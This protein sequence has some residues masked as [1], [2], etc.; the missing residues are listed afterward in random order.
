MEDNPKVHDR[1]A[2]ELPLNA[3]VAPLEVADPYNPEDRIVVL[4]SIST[5]PLAWM[6]SHNRIDDASYAAGREWQAIF[7]R[8]TLGNIR[9]ID[10]TKEAVSGGR[11]P[12]SLTDSRIKAM[13]RL[14]K[15]DEEL[16]PE[17]SRLVFDI[18]GRGLFPNQAAQ[19][20]GKYGEYA[21]RSMS[22]KFKRALLIVAVELGFAN[23]QKSRKSLANP[24]IRT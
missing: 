2:V 4:R 14:R 15:L 3:K 23:S 5:D 20:R 18:L 21:A 13:A 22:R 6:H 11:F 19:E 17:L 1:K 24:R 16:K 12:D 7:A 9:S 8:S 10:T